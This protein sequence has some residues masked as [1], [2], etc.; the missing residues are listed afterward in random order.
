MASTEEPSARTAAAVGLEYTGPAEEPIGTASE[1]GC[2]YCTCI[3][4][5]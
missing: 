5:A 1:P 2:T 3:G 4:G